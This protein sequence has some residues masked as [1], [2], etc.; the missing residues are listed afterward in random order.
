MNCSN[1]MYGNSVGRT[2]PVLLNIR[3]AGLA[4]GLKRLAVLLMFGML[5]AGNTLVEAQ[6][7]PMYSQ[8]MFNMLNVNPA[9]AGNSGADNVTLLYRMQWAGV[10]GAPRTGTFSWDRRQAESNVGYGLQIYNDRLG[11][12]NTTGFQAFYSYRLRFQK[13]NL[14]LGLSAGALNYQATYS[15]VAVIQGNDPR[16]MEDVNSILPSIG[17]GAIY[18]AERIYVGFSIPALL[19]TKID[20]NNEPVVTSANNHYFLTGGYI[21]DLSD[22][23]KL[24]PSLLVKAVKGSP[25]AVDINMNAWFQDKVGLGVSYRT[26]DALVGLFEMQL[27]PKFRVGYAYDFVISNLKTYNLGGSHELML[28]YEF[29]NPKNQRVMSPRYY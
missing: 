5:L 3:V 28:R 20:N 21:F 22:A 27:S 26:G 4:N 8:Y 16:F 25:L 11:I 6:Q 12:E 17:F 29:N 2:C 23:V 24:K 14:T 18:S 9:Y 13:S 7:E 1:R 19:N 10:D 15:R